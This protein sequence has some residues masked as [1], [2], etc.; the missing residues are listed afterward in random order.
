MGEREQVRIAIIGTGG[1]ARTHLRALTSLPEVQLAA[2]CD[3]EEGRLHEAARTWGRPE[4]RTYT[5]FRRMLDEVRPDGVWVLV[6]VPATFEVTAECL[7]RGFDTM[8]EKPP[9]LCTDE[10]RELAALAERHGCKAM[11]AFNRRFNP[12]VRR[13]WEAVTSD[14]DRPAVIVM[15]Y[16]KGPQQFER[17]PREVN[18]RWI[19]VDAIHGLDLLRHL[20]GTVRDVRARS[21]CHLH[22]DL[23]D[24]FHG[25]IEFEGAGSA[26]GGQTIGHLIS[27]YTSVPKIERL[28]LFG[29]RR[30]AVVEGIGS[31]MNT[32]RLFIDGTYR[33]LSLPAEDTQG[34]DT[35][36]Y[37]A[38]DRYFVQ[39]L[40]QD[41]A[42]AAPAASLRDAIVT[43]ELVDRFLAGW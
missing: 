42:P 8:L 2:L 9:G 41:R 19:G 30:W 11:V 36:G 5:D 38:E 29:D 25:L 18:E 40:L 32:G 26:S 15:E 31:G 12:W 17:Y 16:H 21:D 27:T 28:Q 1:I 13:A 6:S 20:G 35:L 10:T 22:G 37:W 24:S 34:T 33:E 3:L 4:T 14:G 43:M 23:P 7:R 39:C